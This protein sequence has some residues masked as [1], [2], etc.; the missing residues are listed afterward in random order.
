MADD[1]VAEATRTPE[2]ADT[3]S[4]NGDEAGQGGHTGFQKA[5]QAWRSTFWQIF[6]TVL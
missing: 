4:N 3:F 5:I 1:A 6:L 2:Q